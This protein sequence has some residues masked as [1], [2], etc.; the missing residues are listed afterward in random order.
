MKRSIIAVDFDGT[1]VT[2]EYPEIGREV[3]GAVDT[4]RLPEDPGARLILWTMRSGE[5]LDA[6]V[7]WFSER[8]IDLWGVNQNPDQIETQWTTSPKAY[9]QIYIDDA[10]LGCPLKLKDDA[11]RPYVDWKRVSKILEERGLLAK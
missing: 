5:Y 11:A 4:L 1:V 7:E 3:E 6:A 8:G 2:H 9:A 10:A